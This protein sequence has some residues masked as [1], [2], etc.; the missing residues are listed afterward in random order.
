MPGVRRLGSVDAVELGRVA[1]GLV[2]LHDRLLRREDDGRP[3]RRALGCEQE[4][5]RLLADARRLS[6]EVEPLDEL[7]AALDADARVLA[8]IAP[9]LG[10]VPGGRVGVDPAAGLVDV[11]LD[12]RPLG[13]DE[14]LVLALGAHHRDGDLDVGVLHALFRAQAE[15]DLVR[16]RD[17][18]RIAL[19][20][21]SILA[22]LRVDRRERGPVPAGRGAREGG[23]PERGVAGR[24]VVQPPDPGEPP[25]AVD[26]HPDAD[27][28]A[29]GVAQI[30]DL[31]VLRDHGLAPERDRARVRVGRPCAQCR[32]H[33]CLG[34]RLHRPTLPMARPG[35]ARWWRAAL[36]ATSS[37][38]PARDQTKLH[39]LHCAS[40]AGGGIGRRARLRALWG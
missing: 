18:E 25:G 1:D 14:H 33:R 6:V 35:L 4:R 40:R 7:P 17:R 10:H 32:I 8:R 30:V 13:G 19:E 26:E 39:W 16:E 22:R 21:R 29:L 9:D 2:D 34:Q 24:R 15:I 23:C 36:H 11:L 3:P 5:R 27:A 12:V 38:S 37:P 28:L 31:A 20:R